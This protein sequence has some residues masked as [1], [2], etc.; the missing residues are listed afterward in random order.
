[1]DALRITTRWQYCL[2]RYFSS[3][4]HI[5]ITVTRSL[6]SDEIMLYVKSAESFRHGHDRKNTC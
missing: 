5:K 1:M 3:K 2:T 4:Q 6:S